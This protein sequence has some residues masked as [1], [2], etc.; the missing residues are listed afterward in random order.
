M[1]EQESLWKGWALPTPESSS[2]AGLVLPSILHKTQAY[3]IYIHQLGQTPVST[4]GLKAQ[5][6]YFFNGIECVVPIS[7]LL[8]GPKQ[9]R[10]FG[11]C[12]N[13]IYLQEIF[14]VTY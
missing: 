11:R 13:P 10:L 12:C 5:V 6:Y 2:P 3:C 9:I 14:S 1:Q 4:S 7:A 8:S